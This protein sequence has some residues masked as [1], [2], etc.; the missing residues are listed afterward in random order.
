MNQQ[1]I[2]QLIQVLKNTPATEQ[3]QLPTYFFEQHIVTGF[4]KQARERW[5]MH[6]SVLVIVVVSCIDILAL[7]YK[8][9]NTWKS[10]SF[11]GLYTSIN[12]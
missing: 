1:K 4:E 6:L 5:G 12:L 9:S 3:D 11:Y 7:Y 10:S 8:Y 2:E